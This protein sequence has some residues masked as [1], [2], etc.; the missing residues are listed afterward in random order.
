MTQFFGKYRGTVIQ[1]FDTEQRGRILVSVPAVLGT[2]QGW[3]MPSVPY[4]GIQA[5]IYAIPPP[6]AKIWVEFEGGNPE[7]PIWTGCFWGMGET[8][9][10]ALAPPLPVSHI[11]LQTT[12]QNTIHISD[13]PGPAGGILLKSGGA[14]IS[15]N[16]TG[17]IISDGTGGTVTLTGGV[18]SIN[19]PALVI[20]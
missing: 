17:I 11:L 3:A 9:T 19:P 20:K 4:A 16:N 7:Y 10:L 8:P 1:N 15:V 14:M 2:G 13:A 6:K 5:G 12:G 18:V